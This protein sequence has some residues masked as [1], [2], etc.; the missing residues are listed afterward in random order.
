M[1]DYIS[2]CFNVCS[3]HFGGPDA[4]QEHLKTLQLQLQVPRNEYI[5][6]L[7]E[8]GDG[9]EVRC[10]FFESTPERKKEKERYLKERMREMS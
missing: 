6:L 9:H 5:L 10:A 1:C 3:L 4:R 8:S 7:C 2:V